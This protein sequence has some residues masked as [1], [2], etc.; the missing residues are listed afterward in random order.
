MVRSVFAFNLI[1]KNSPSID[2]NI[3]IPIGNIGEPTI[4]KYFARLNGKNFT[5]AAEL[6]TEEGYLK[7][8]FEKLI[9]GKKKIADYFEK[10]ATGI[11]CYPENGQLWSHSKDIMQQ[12]IHKEYQI[13]GKVQMGLFT[14][15]VQWLIQL[16][17]ANEFMAVEV[18]LLTDLNELLKFN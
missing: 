7:P 1:M 3:L 11:T 18:K 13:Q 14:V 12:V 8:P 2:Q 5:E 9:K 16:N 17:H 10:E 15:N 6:F 4:H